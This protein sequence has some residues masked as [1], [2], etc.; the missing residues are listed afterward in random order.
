MKKID[1]K[2]VIA[3]RQDGEPSILEG[4]AL[5]IQ[6]SD[7][8]GLIEPLKTYTGEKVRV[9]IQDADTWTDRMNKL[10]HALIRK[11]HVAGA[12]NYWSKLQKAPESFEETKAYI[13]V[14]LCGAELKQVG[15]LTWIESWKDFSKRRAIK[16]I[17]NVIDYC[18]K[19]DVDIDEEKIEADDLRR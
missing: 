7:P 12:V 1:C 4:G 8:R 11:I 14:T 10:F 16:A 5:K 17:D 13:K 6:P 19:M 15:E 3:P 9:V 18:Y 2:A